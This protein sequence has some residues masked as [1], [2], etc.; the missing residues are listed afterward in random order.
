MKFSDYQDDQ[1]EYLY[2]RHTFQMFKIFMDCFGLKIEYL[3]HLF[4]LSHP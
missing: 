2:N 3:T 1:D 4:Y